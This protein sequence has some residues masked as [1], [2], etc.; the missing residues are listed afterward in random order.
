VVAD[1]RR[2]HVVVAHCPALLSKA[3]QTAHIGACDSGGK[4]IMPCIWTRTLPWM[5]PRSAVHAHFRYVS[6]RPSG[7][8]ARVTVLVAV[9]TLARA[10]SKRGV[11]MPAAIRLD[12]RCYPA[13]NW[14]GLFIS[15]DF[16]LGCTLEVAGRS[17]HK[18]N[19]LTSLLYVA[20]P[21]RCG[22]LVGQIAARHSRAA[23]LPIR[24]PDLPRGAG[25]P[26]WWPARGR[27][28]CP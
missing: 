15:F 4:A 14:N 17:R 11:L 21:T 22:S 12:A 23:R 2:Y 13:G 8:P 27:R 7:G 19:D 20:I 24:P 16:S 6:G 26:L 5:H 1:A 3:S 28:G 9:S 25:R 10:K 18:I